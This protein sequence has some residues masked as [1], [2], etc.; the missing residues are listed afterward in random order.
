[1]FQDFRCCE[2]P[3]CLTTCGLA[4]GLQATSRARFGQGPQSEIK[5]SCS[6]RGR[7]TS[8]SRYIAI[9]R[10][11]VEQP[12]KYLQIIMGQTGFLTFSFHPKYKVKAEPHN[13]PTFLQ[14]L[15]SFC[16][17]YRGSHTLGLASSTIDRDT[18]TNP[19]HNIEKELT[20]PANDETRR[21]QTTRMELTAAIIATYAPRP[22][23]IAIDNHTVFTG[24]RRIKD[25]GDK[26][27]RWINKPDGDLWQFLG[28]SY[29]CEGC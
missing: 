2:A 25:R 15:Q 29:R 26:P 6:E 7:T 18:T 17:G 28:E 3:S 11:R 24:F 16:R 9:S 10:W 20:E 23:T 12:D 14:M 27:T 4:W 19:L 13:W 8:G 22:I 5:T 21:Q 1:M